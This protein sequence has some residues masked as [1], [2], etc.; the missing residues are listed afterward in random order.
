MEQED[1]EQFLHC[2]GTAVDTV[3]GVDDHFAR[4]AVKMTA[5]VWDHAI[6]AAGMIGLFPIADDR[7]VST[8]R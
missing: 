3:S 6:A 8:R 5:G 1:P 2:T 4:G 7:M